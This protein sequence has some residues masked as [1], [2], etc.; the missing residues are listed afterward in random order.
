MVTV[1]RTRVVRSF[2]WSAAVV[3][4]SVCC[5]ALLGDVCC[6]LNQGLATSAAA[7]RQDRATSSSQACLRSVHPPTLD[8]R[9]P[10]LKFVDVTGDGLADVLI[11]EDDAF[12]F[13]TSLG[14]AGF[15][16]GQRV[17][18]CPPRSVPWE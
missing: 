16:S 17:L 9:N 2:P 6:R 10:N 3:R 4:W 15:G 18:L 7:K 13:H 12:W 11:S 14:A 1:A 8:W 5:A